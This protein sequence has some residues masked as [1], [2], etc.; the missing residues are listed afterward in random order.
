LTEQRKLGKSGL[1]VSAVGLGTNSFGGRMADYEPCEAVVGAAIDAGVTFIDTANTYSTGRS[2]EFIGRAVAGRRDEVLIATKAA[3]GMGDGPNR[4]GTSCKHPMAE[5][6]AS[7][8]R[9]QT[10]YIDVFQVHFADQATPTEETMRALDDLAR[11][12]KI[13]YVGASNHAAWQICEA[14]WT[15]RSLG[16]NAFISVQPAYSLLNRSAE[17]ELIPFCR[18]YGVGV[19]PYSPLG[20]GMLTGKYRSGEEPPEGT[21]F[22]SMRG[23]FR[24]RFM[25]EG[26]F[27]LVDA[28]DAFARE[29]EH[30]VLELAFAWLLAQ[31]T[32]STVIAGATKPEQVRAN[33]EASEWKL[34][35][36]DL[37]SLEELLNGSG[38]R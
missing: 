33:S 27:Q 35:S 2:E 3:G 16:L 5:V 1:G 18:E 13:L 6:E 11:Q 37:I 32:V 22:A 30:T 14:I 21:R 24:D 7:L 28:L 36:E 8:K 12:G 9:L 19:I 10:D 29:R 20:G 4:R 15:S 23:R 34:T 25:N 17:Q 31:P 26:N 38:S